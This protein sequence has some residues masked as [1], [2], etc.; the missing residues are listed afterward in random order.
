ML[1]NDNFV[2]LKHLYGSMPI[3]TNSATN[4]IPQ[5]LKE[6]RVFRKYQKYL[7]L[8]SETVKSISLYLPTTLLVGAIAFGQ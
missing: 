6:K 5:T 4:S 1:Q 7:V 3:Y 2:K 8:K